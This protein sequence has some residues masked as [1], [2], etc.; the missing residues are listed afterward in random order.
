MREDYTIRSLRWRLNLQ[1]RIGAKLYI[2]L[3]YEY[4]N[5]EMIEVEEGRK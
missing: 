1:K 4:E 3:Q 5:S 2:E